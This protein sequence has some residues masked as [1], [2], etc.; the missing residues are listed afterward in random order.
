MG[1][2]VKNHSPRASNRSFNVYQTY[3]AIGIY[4]LNSVYK[5]TAMYFKVTVLTLLPCSPFLRG[6]NVQQ[7]NTEINH[8]LHDFRLH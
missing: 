5:Y 8:G 2:T 3:I 7:F 4:K 1:S 6:L